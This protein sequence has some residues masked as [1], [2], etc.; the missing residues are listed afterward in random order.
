MHTVQC[1][2]Y[3]VQCTLTVIPFLYHAQTK[4]LTMKNV[5]IKLD[6]FGSALL[7]S[8]AW[9]WLIIK[10]CIVMRHNHFT[11]TEIIWIF[12]YKPVSADADATLNV[13][14][15][16]T[17][18]YVYLAQKPDKFH[19]IRLHLFHP[20]KARFLCWYSD[21]F[22]RKCIFNLRRNKQEI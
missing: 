5:T 15:L 6:F 13:R 12:A 3:T 22:K 1:T 17:Y 4:F 21:W 16:F 18:E 9:H 2:V 14:L 7:V 20:R 19:C 8:S 11:V 10:K